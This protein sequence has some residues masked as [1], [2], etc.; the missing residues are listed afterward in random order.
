[1]KLYPSKKA[2]ELKLDSLFSEPWR[3]YEVEN[4]T[5]FIGNY[6]HG[7]QPGHSQP[8]MY[9]FVGRQDKA[10]CVL[11]SIMNHYYD[12]GSQHLALAGMDDAGEMSAWFVFNAIGLYTY[13]PADAEYLVTVPL[14][15]RV[16]FRLN[17]GRTFSIEHRGSGRRITSISYGGRPVKGWFLSDS[18]L[19]EGRQLVVQTS[20]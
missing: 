11:D 13:S 1:M 2:V 14:F 7:N 20:E 6:C 5:G 10:Q 3:G 16:S 15:P 9:Y 18:L 8:Y 4:L 12:M 19:Q 17:N